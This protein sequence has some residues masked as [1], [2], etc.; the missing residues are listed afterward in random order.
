MAADARGNDVGAVGIPVTGA[1]AIAPEG[2]AI[3]TPNAGAQPAY[4]LPAAFRRPGLLTE[5][6]GFE[7]TMEPDG[8]PIVFWQEGYSIPSGAAKCELK[9]IFAQTDETVRSIIR[10]KTADANGYITIDAGGT[11]KKYVIWTEEIFKNA[12]VRRRVAPNAS[13]LS[14]KEAKNTRGEVLGYETT[15]RIDRHPA[16]ANE[17]IGE[18]LIPATAAADAVP[19]V[20]AVEGSPDPAKA[21]EL[22]VITGTGFTGTA[23]VKFGATAATDYTVNSST[24]IT[25]VMPSGS[26]GAVNVVVANPVGSSAPFSYTR[27]A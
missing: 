26:A 5:D 18:W 13:V 16:V 2:T 23:S 12:V 4:T 8:D 7:W 24:Q 9:V 11:S 1:I 21:G 10:G 19:A 14:V 15:F 22:V 25:A 3:P 27:G 20:T 17:H 6:G